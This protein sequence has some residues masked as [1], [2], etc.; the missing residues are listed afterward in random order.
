MKKV[1]IALC[2]SV[3]LISSGVV[4][5]ADALYRMLHADEVESFKKDQDAIIVGW[6]VEKKDDKFT[7]EVLKV[8]SGKVESNSILVSGA[9]MDSDTEN[10]QPL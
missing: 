9:V 4:F 10:L 8:V 5:A 3:L 6:L 7:V 1:L 2:L